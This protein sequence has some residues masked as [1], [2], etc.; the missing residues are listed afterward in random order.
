MTV[1]GLVMND[2]SH[3]LLLSKLFQ[4]VIFLQSITLFR[5]VDTTV[6]LEFLSGIDFISNEFLFLMT[7]IIMRIFLLTVR[8]SILFLVFHLLYWQIGFS[9][10]QIFFE[11]WVKKEVD[12]SLSIYTVLLGLIQSIVNF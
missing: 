11:R 4:N 6:S 7:V 9:T 10:L 2:L 1:K 5:L 12:I 3:I 8:T